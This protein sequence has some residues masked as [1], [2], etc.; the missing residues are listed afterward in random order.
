MTKIFKSLFLKLKQLF[1]KKTAIYQDKSTNSNSSAT[2]HTGTGNVYN[3][4]KH[5][6]NQNITAESLGEKKVYLKKYIIKIFSLAYSKD[7]D[8]INSN[9]III[10]EINKN[11]EKIDIILLDDTENNVISKEE[12]K[13]VK[14]FISN[15]RTFNL[16]ASTYALAK[17]NDTVNPDI[18][19]RKNIA[20]IN[21]QDSYNKLTQI[22]L[23]E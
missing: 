21:L 12:K 4:N 23:F 2:I 8:M 10:D 1:S 7:S 20:D 15:V 18:I 13:I 3:D 14:E 19:S 9:N 16:Y 22:K 5:I 11:S 17:Q 6:V